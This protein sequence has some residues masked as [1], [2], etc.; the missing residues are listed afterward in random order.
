MMDC[1][2][3][4][5]DSLTPWGDGWIACMSCPGLFAPPEPPEPPTCADHI[6]QESRES[7]DDGK[8]ATY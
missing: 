1:P 8:T 3:C 4:G 2:E 5:I 7:K 6:L